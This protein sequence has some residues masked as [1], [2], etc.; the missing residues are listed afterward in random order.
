MVWKFAAAYMLSMIFAAMFLLA[1]RDCIWPPPGVGAVRSRWLPPLVPLA[2]LVW[3]IWL[4]KR[5]AALL[6]PH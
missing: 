6:P 1:L 5:E 2:L 4:I 3:A